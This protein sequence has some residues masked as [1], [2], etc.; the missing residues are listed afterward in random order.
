ML[1]Q[2]ETLIIKRSM[3]FRKEA[4]EDPTLN[5]P[6]LEQWATEICN[7]HGRTGF[8]LLH[9]THRKCQGS[10]LSD[11]PDA[12]SY[13]IEATFKR[14]RLM[15]PLHQYGLD[16]LEKERQKA[17]GLLDTEEDDNAE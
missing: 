4:E 16:E 15:K 17:F 7:E 14:P 13:E 12:C 2:W 9:E 8:E 11:H 10:P 1:Q 3:T 5:L 6:T